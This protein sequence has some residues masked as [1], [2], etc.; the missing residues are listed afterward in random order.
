MFNPFLSWYNKIR[1]QLD[2]NLLWPQ[3]KYQSKGDTSLAR[4]AFIYHA[5]IDDA[6]SDLTPKEI[7]NIVNNLN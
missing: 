4:E 2:I 1:R 5:L 6:W 3:L 7:E